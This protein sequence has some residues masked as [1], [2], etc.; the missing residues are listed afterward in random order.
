MSDKCLAFI[1]DDPGTSPSTTSTPSSL[2]VTHETNRLQFLIDWSAMFQKWEEVFQKW[3]EVIRLFNAELYRIFFFLIVFS[4]Q[5]FPRYKTTQL[6]IMLCHCTSCFFLH[7]HLKVS[8]SSS[9][10]QQSWALL[11]RSNPEWNCREGELLRNLSGLWKSP[12]AGR[13]SPTAFTQNTW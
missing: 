11:G 2:L 6:S 10:P 7:S 5:L 13:F 8:K 3:E 9:L 12:R 1:R 4:S